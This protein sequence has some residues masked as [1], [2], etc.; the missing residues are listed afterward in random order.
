MGYGF[1]EPDN[2]CDQV[3][4]RLGPVAPEVHARLRKRLPSHWKSETWTEQEATFYI[5]DVLHYSSGYLDLYT[6][7]KFDCLRG[8]PPALACSLYEIVLANNEQDIDNEQ[9]GYESMIWAGVVDALLQRAEAA[10]LAI[11]RWDGRLPDIPR[12][13]K[14]KAAATYRKGQVRILGNV[15]TEFRA[16]MDVLRTGEVDVRDAFSR[17]VSG[18]N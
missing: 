2:P 10:S 9:P 3:A 16:V 12:S 6:H 18:E 8:V 17:G 14:T 5:R 7:G 4:F 11:T 13:L 15:I 1:C